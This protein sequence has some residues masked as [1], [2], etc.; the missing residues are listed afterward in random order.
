MTMPRSKIPHEDSPDLTP[1]AADEAD[2]IA[3]AIAQADGEVKDEQE[4]EQAGGG[5]EEDEEMDEM[6]SEDDG[7]DYEAER[8]RI[9]KCVPALSQTAPPFDSCV[10][11]TI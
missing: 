2:P 5:G 10:K 1:L 7:E 4:Q 9:I 11:G 8:Q 3:A 6:G